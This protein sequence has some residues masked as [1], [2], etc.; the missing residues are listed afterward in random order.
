MKLQIPF[1]LDHNYE[2]N[3][4]SQKETFMS[5]SKSDSD[6]ISPMLEWLKFKEH[7]C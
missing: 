1:V 3:N 6:S 4:L 5:A 7:R 2:P